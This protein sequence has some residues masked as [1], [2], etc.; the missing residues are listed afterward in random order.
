MNTNIHRTAVFILLWLAVSSAG[1]AGVVREFSG[2]SSITT[3]D[4]EVNGPWI[5]DWRA[6]GDFPA[7]LGFEASL[8][9]ARTGKHLGQIVKISD[10]PGDGV[11]LFEQGGRYRIRIDSTLARWHIKIEEIRKQDLDLYTP[12]SSR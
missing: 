9:N 12:K 11:K 10:R 5:L 6:N 2:T 3:A 8:I 1:S 7:M 4:F